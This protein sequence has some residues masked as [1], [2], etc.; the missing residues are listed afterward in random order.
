M[1]GQGESG[2]L[3]RGAKTYA[4]ACAIIASIIS[5]LMGYD[6]GVM[7]GAMLFMKEDLNIQDEQVEVLA[8]I[9]NICALVG[10]LTAGRLSDWIGRRYTIVVASIIFF[11]GAVLMGLGLNYGMLFSGRCIAGVG[12]GYAL[13]VA[14]VYSAEISSPSSRG[15]LT[16]LPEIC[17]SAGILLGY[18]SNYFLRHLPLKYGWRLMLGVAAVPSVMLAVGILAMPESPRWLVMQGR[19]REARE[20]LLR[21][22]N[23][24]EEAELRLREIK[25]AA[26]VDESCT[27]D[28]VEPVATHRG[29]GVWK[30][31]LL[32]PTPAVRRILIAALGIHF[33]EHATGIEAVVLYTPRIFKKAGISSRSKL[34]FVTMG[35]GVT[36]TAFIL[37]A[38]FLLDKVGRRP[39][40]LTSVAGMIVSLSSLGIGLTMADH[41]QQ[42]LPWALGLCIAS[43][44]L[45]VAFFSVGLAPVTWVYS[46]EIFPL[47]L[48]AQGA[49]MGVAVNRLMNG[50][51]S[52]TFISLYKAITIGGAFF[53]FA[54]I[55][56]LAWIFFF[57]CCP[58][59]K[60]VSLERI[61]EVFSKGCDR[62]SVAEGEG[63]AMANVASPNGHLRSSKS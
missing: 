56:I 5:I 55:A 13:M 24:K 41:S 45:F 2:V 59:T 30:E 16:S 58:E 57:F 61:E 7:S 40:L 32:R 1:E 10:S 39:L 37:V 20:V 12:V 19:L 28:V 38:T 26:G 46:S 17:I 8:G 43:L 31:L 51:V 33:F 3:A 60:G 4:F 54:G 23:T 48:R 52:M 62:S 22:S 6:T 9:M 11:V 49:S 42:T 18:V 47:R 34:L 27:D 15:F 35:M 63:V 21:V 29:E 50:T 44:L 53:L 25:A 14:P 36:K